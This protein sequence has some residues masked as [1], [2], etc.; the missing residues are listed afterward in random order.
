[1]NEKMKYQWIDALRSGKF[2]QCARYLKVFLD[3][4]NPKDC[5]HCAIGVL[6]ELFIPDKFQAVEGTF[7]N[8]FRIHHVFSKLKPVTGI[9]EAL[10]A[11]VVNCNDNGGSYE[12]CAKLIESFEAV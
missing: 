2:K 8:F 1:M 3:E 9:N 6:A 11:A 5:S 4:K 10:F 12:D 7:Y